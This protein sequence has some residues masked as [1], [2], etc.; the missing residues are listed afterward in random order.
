MKIPVTT[1]R[2]IRCP[3]CG[4][5]GWVEKKAAKAVDR[6]LHDPRMSVYRCPYNYTYWHVGTLPAPVVAGDIPRSEIY[7]P[8]PR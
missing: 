7:L 3:D 4:K 5:R 6:R 1:Q 2:W 8:R